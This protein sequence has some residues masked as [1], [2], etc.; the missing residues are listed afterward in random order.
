MVTGA[1]SGIGR[2]LAERFVAEHMKVVLA[3]VESGPLHEAAA[4]LAES[5]DVL[6]VRTD[7]ADR[8]QVEHLRDAALEHFGI[9]NVVCNNAGVGAGGLLTDCPPENWRWVLDVDLFGVIWGVQAFL[10]HLLSHGDGHIVN[11]GSIASLISFPGMGPYNVAKYGVAA[12]TETLHQEL[13]MTGSTVGTTLLCPGFVA[14]RILD[15]ERNRPEG[16][17]PRNAAEPPAEMAALREVAQDLYR[18]QKPPADVAGCVVDAIVA[19]QLYCY[20][21][22]AF[23]DL[24]AARSAAVANGTDLPRF[25][26]LFERLHP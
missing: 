21:D 13:L 4:T 3:D 25:G 15:S 23:A 11:T 12:L 7:V 1:A 20:T 26:M 14:T 16:L 8:A 17:A 19:K 24:I 22:D 18:V 2:A 5:G 6:A 10:P 9:V